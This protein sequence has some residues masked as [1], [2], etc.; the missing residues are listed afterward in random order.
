MMRH[1][2]ILCVLF[3]FSL[4]IISCNTPTPGNGTTTV[5]QGK[6]TKNNDFVKAIAGEEQEYKLLSSGDYVDI[7]IGEPFRLLIGDLDPEYYDLEYSFDFASNSGRIEVVRR[8]S[9]R[10]VVLENK[11]Q[12][13]NIGPGVIPEIAVKEEMPKHQVVVTPR[14]NKNCEFLGYEIRYGSIEEGCKQGKSNL[15]TLRKC[16]PIKKKY[17]RG[18]NQDDYWTDILFGGND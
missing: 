2:R 8:T 12:I 7:K 3:L 11:C 6:V 10:I 13:K 18:Q 15:N 4:L 16:F 5:I 17:V 9:S 14:Y 1:L